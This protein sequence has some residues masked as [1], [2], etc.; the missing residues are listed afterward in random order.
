MSGDDTPASSGLPAELTELPELADF[1][2]DLQGLA[3]G[4]DAFDPLTNAVVF[5]E[6]V[7]D[8]AALM[9]T[10]IAATGDGRVADAACAAFL[11]LHHLR[12]IRMAD[13]AI[14]RIDATDDGVPKIVGETQYRF[15]FFR[16]MARAL[17]D[18][19]WSP[20]PEEMQRP[21]ATF[22]DAGTLMMALVEVNDHYDEIFWRADA[23][24]GSYAQLREALRAADTVVTDGAEAHDFVRAVCNLPQT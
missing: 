6:C 20:L 8:S 4:A 12:L 7:C 17:R 1:R 23:V 3:F 16:S 21:T 22:L 18:T 14:A 13:A 11:G 15:S 5:E 19:L 10:S 2:M 24:A 9:V